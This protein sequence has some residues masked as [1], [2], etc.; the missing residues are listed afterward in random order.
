MN[1]Q[2][3]ANHLSDPPITKQLCSKIMHAAVTSCSFFTVMLR[4]INY[5]CICASPA[6]THTL[7]NFHYAPVVQTRSSCYKPNCSY[8]TFLTSRFDL[9]TRRRTYRKTQRRDVPSNPTLMNSAAFLF[10]WCHVA[11][12]N[13][14][15]LTRSVPPSQKPSA[16][17]IAVSQHLPFLSIHAVLATSQELQQRGASQ[18]VVKLSEMD[19]QHSYEKILS[20]WNFWTCRWRFIRHVSHVFTNAQL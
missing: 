8:W 5:G 18:L 3:A 15:M 10:C 2:V 11:L 9:M 6:N 1:Q 14:E 20:R 12:I 4:D 16:I 7:E 13:T 17:K 19:L